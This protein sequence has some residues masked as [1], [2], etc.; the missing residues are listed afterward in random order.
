MPSNYGD[1]LSH[2]V[3]KPRT[4]RPMKASKYCTTYQMHEQRGSYQGV[5]TCDV[6]NFGDFSFC[7]MILD[8]HESKSIA[9]RPDINS[10]LLKLEKEK[11]LCQSTVSSMQ[12]RAKDWYADNKTKVEKSLDGST[13]VP[14][15][16]ALYTHCIGN[17]DKPI[18]V[19]IDN[20]KDDNRN[21]LPEKTL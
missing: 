11:V 8:E 12:K 14:L 21:L 3:I 18:K 5:D 1:Q 4:I 7:S 17:I 20:R 2:A 16:D 19:I 10:L 6:T 9:C 15:D 13:Y